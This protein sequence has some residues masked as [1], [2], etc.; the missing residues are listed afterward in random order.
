M[1][2]RDVQLQLCSYPT[3]TSVAAIEQAMDLAAALG[4]RI[5]ALTFK[6]ELPTTSNMLANT[7]LEIPS[8]IAAE[9]QKS[10][11]NAQTLVSM[12]ESIALKRGVA[13][14]QFI[15]TCPTSQMGAIL[16]EH[17]R[18]RDLTMIPIGEQATVQ[19]YVAE[20]VIFG[21]G[22]PVIIFPEAP[23]RR[24]STPLDVVAVAWDFSRPAARAVADALPILQAAKTVRVVTI[25][26]EKK[27]DTRRSAAELAKHLACH[28]VEVVL[29]EED[30][31]G[32]T[33]G[34]ALEA[35]LDA[36]AIDL[37]VMGAYGHSRMRDFVLGG[38]TKAIVGDPPL[39]VFLSH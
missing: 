29:D 6:I 4:A 5:S 19:Q 13:H 10:A 27:I 38:A 1:A 20:S 37:L 16:T 24:S 30:A 22:R 39:P 26:K 8:M 31:A 23:K 32:R 17:A 7:L 2:I 3:P 36:R 15:E 9:R 35:Y 34:Q 14:E 18:M 33:I 21:S 28:G 11:A 25:T 12:F